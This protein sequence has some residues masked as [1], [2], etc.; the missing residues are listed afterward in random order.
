MYL[1]FLFVMFAS[2]II[3]PDIESQEHDNKGKI[4]QVWDYPYHCIANSKQN[5]YN[6]VV[7]VI[8]ASPVDL[9]S[10]NIFTFI[11]IN[12]CSTNE[13]YSTNTYAHYDI[14]YKSFMG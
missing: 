13:F 6:I 1:V 3:T 8:I 9:L 14:V 2:S 12:E 5:D 11:F 7:L 10:K 4:D